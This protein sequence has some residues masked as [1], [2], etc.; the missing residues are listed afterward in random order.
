MWLTEENHK[1]LCHCP[2]IYG[3][4]CFS[5]CLFLFFHSWDSSCLHMEENQPSPHLIPGL[6]PGLKLM[7]GLGE[8]QLLTYFHRYIA[9]VRN[10]FLKHMHYKKSL[11]E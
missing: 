3:L 10:P 1:E 4:K 8:Q 7:A 6:S 5:F 2:D 9:Q 11:S